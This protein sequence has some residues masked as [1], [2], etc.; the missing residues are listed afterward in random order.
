M[1]N[2]PNFNAF[3]AIARQQK[4]IERTLPPKSILDGITRAEKVHR[5][6]KLFN[7]TNFVN[8]YNPTYNAL[9][10]INNIMQSRLNQHKQQFHTTNFVSNYYPIQRVLRNTPGLATGIINLHNRSF[11]AIDFISRINSGYNVIKEINSLMSGPLN[12]NMRSLGA[13]GFAYQKLGNAINEAIDKFEKN[14]VSETNIEELL[15]A[16]YNSIVSFLRIKEIPRDVKLFIAGLIISTF[17]A[18]ISMV[19][20]KQLSDSSTEQIVS[21]VEL[22]N[23]KSSDMVIGS[24]NTTGDKIMDTIIEYNNKLVNL[25]NEPYSTIHTCKV[26]HTAKCRAAKDQIGEGTYVSLTDYK[27]GSKVF[28]NYTT[29]D[30]PEEPQSGWIDKKYVKKETPKP[31]RKNKPLPIRKFE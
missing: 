27:L 23:R 11:K 4:L 8:K 15:Q 17:F 25:I 21:S 30:C 26:Y 3:N 12:N 24:I 2:Y 10:G 1:N 5:P 9:T 7:A 20:S 28:I 22:E 18:Y 31:K 16:F 14:E 19:Y 29:D 6:T 13:T